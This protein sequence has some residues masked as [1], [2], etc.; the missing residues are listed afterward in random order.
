[1]RLLIVTMILLAARGARADDAE[2]RRV[3]EQI[4]SGAIKSVRRAVAIGPTIGGYGAYATSPGEADAALSFGL[5][6]ALFKSKVLSPSGLQEMVR[7]RIEAKL[8]ARVD[9]RHGGTTPDDATMKQYVREIID[10]VKA[11]LVRE[12][13]APPKKLQQPR[14]NLA[15]E[16]NYLFDASDWLGRLGLGIGIKMFS[17][18]PTFSVR[19]GED[20]VARL[21]GELGIHIMPT[22]SLRSPV[23]D[24]FVRGDFELHKRESKDD[25][26]VVGIR[27]LLDVI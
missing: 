12:L 3:A 2:N 21:G 23:F 14:F 26:I 13:E 11:E 27:L 24:I 6:I 19:F 20:T 4:A 18:G 25:Q 10:E 22:K 7:G 15:L 5:E 9:L 16:A 17:I 1:M 8:K